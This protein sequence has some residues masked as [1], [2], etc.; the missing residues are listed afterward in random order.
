MTCV[1]LVLFRG[2]ISAMKNKNVL[3]SMSPEHQAAFIAAIP[4][5][6]RET[7]LEALRH[8][9]DGLDAHEAVGSF[10]SGVSNALIHSY[11]SGDI[12]ALPLRFARTVINRE[13]SL[14]EVLERVNA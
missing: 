11:E 3:F 5:E 2:T 4:P 14:E 9:Y 7:F 1:D 12:L 6:K 13:E 8:Y 10:L